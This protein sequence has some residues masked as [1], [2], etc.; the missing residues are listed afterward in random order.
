MPDQTTHRSIYRR[1][2]WYLKGM[3][4][5]FSL[6]GLILVSSFVGFAALAKDAGVTAAQAVFMTG[7]V[8]ALPSMVVLVGAIVSGAILPA[9]ML[10][11]TLS[12]IRLMPMVMAL[13]PE[14]RADKTRPWVLYLLSHFVAVTS[15]VLAMERLRHIPRDMRA[16][17]YAGL[18][19]TLVLTN[20]I[21]VATV[22]AV[23]DRL[24]STVSAMLLLLTPMYFLT[25]LWG[26]ARER[27]G[28]LA[29][30]LGLG[31][32]PL[33][34]VLVPKLDL[35]AAGLVGGTAAY[36][37]HRWRRKARAA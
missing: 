5:A 16:T 9:A 7:I 22:Y 37:W 34:H 35:L 33:F 21:V 25:S 24:P 11:V 23:A 10:A 32:G 3:R 36:G 13:L 14:M 6:P 26:S 31:L 30:V 12:A 27:A 28:H 18:G 17:Y 29:M 1:R 15:W 8:W 2:A 20:M 4:G 19:S